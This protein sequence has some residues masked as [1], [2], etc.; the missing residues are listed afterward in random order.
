MRKMV[1]LILA[2]LACSCSREEPRNVVVRPEGSA[3]LVHRTRGS[4]RGGFELA[5]SPVVSGAPILVRFWVE[6]TGSSPIRFRQ[7]GDWYQKGPLHFT[8]LVSDA[9][10]K[11]ECDLRAR[12]EP[13]SG[14][15]HSIDK[16]LAP[17]QRDEQWLAPQTGCDALLAPGRHRLRGVRILADETHE[18]DECRAILVPDTTVSPPDDRGVKESPAC[19]AWL[20]AAPAIASEF[21][22]EVLRYEAGAVRAAITSEMAVDG[23]EGR[24]GALGQYAMWLAFRLGREPEWGANPATQLQRLAAALPAALPAR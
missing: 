18:P 22:V 6:N 16:T 21:E 2:L 11:V 17:G 19:L 12:P 4:V 9:S 14:G 8:W 15:G 20:L 13:M 23:G 24:M 5:S 1:P 3:G 10:G 7:G